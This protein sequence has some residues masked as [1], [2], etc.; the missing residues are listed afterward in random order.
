MPNKE[1]TQPVLVKVLYLF[2][3]KRR[4]SDVSTFLKRL[5]EAGKIRLQ[6]QEFDI[7]RSETHD[8][9]S[10][11]LWEQI[12][13]TLK[14]GGWFL[15]VSPPCNTFS[16][17]RFQWR[18]YPGP[19]PLRSR[20][21]PKGFPWL[22]NVNAKIVNEANEFVLQCI[23][24]CYVVVQHDG[25]FL[26]EHPEDLGIVDGEVP[27]SIWQ[28]EEI[29]NLLAWCHGITMAI[30]Q[31]QFGALTS[32]PTRLMC[33]FQVRD[34][35]CHLGFP[36]FDKNYRYLG[37]LPPKCGHRHTY[38]LMGKTGNRWNT[39]P[40]AAY[41]PG[42]CKFIAD[43]I[44]G[45]VATC[46][47]G[48]KNGMA[49]AHDKQ[50]ATLESSGAGAPLESSVVPSHKAA[51][52]SQSTTP[53]VAPLESSDTPSRTTMS[54][55]D[56]APLTT[57]TGPEEGQNHACTEI[58]NDVVHETQGFDMESCL[59]KGRPISVEWDGRRREFVDGFG[60]CSPTRWAPLARGVRRSDTMKKLASETFVLLRE[61]VARC[62]P[63]VRAAAFKLVTGKFESSPFSFEEL[64][65]LR[66]K[67][68]SLLADPTDALVV[69]EG[70]PFLLRGL[71]QW[72]TVFE[73]PDAPT[74]VDIEDSFAT[75][76]PLGVDAPLPRTPQVY[77]EKVKH[78]KLDDSEFN[79]IANNYQSAQV[80]STELET[81]FR[82]EEAM[83]R[84]YPTRLS[85]LKQE[86]GEE[87]IRVAAMAAIAKPDGTVRPL[88]DGTHSV[89][90]NNRIV[91]RDQIQC[92]GP[93]EVAAVVRESVETLEAPFCVSADIKAAHRLV[94]VRRCDW[95]YMCCKA[96]TDSPTVWVNKVGTFG[97]SSAPY[98]WAKLFAMVGRFVGHL[99]MNAWFLHL[100]YVDDLHG[101][102]VGKEKFSNL[103]V[104]ILAFELIG[105]PFAYHKFRG[106][107][108]SEFVGY[109]L[110]YDLNEV[111][112]SLRR[113]EW[114]V[115]WI[116]TAA[117]KRFVVVTREFS[118]FLGR[119]GFVSQLL[120]WLKPHLSPLY[121][122]ASATSGSTVA[123]LP[124]A[125]ILTMTYLLTE[126]RSETY[127]VSAKRP[128]TYTG[129]QFRTDAKCTDVSVV[130]G[131]WEMSTGRWF[132]LSLSES[133]VPYL[134]SPGKG[135]QWASTS[136]ELLA[137]L[138]ALVVFGWTGAAR[139]RKELELCLTA[140]TDN[141]ANEYLSQKRSTTKWP[142]MLV[143][144]QLSS[145]L[146]RSRTGVRLKWRPRE[147]NTVADDITN[148]VF[149]QLDMDKRL[150]V[151]YE[152][153]PTEIIHA[154]WQ[155]KAD[156]D[157]ARLL[158]K[159]SIPKES[160]KK[161]KRVDK[162]P[163]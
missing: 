6:L 22:S 83:G 112:I 25:W 10:K 5:E 63:D 103:W 145:V 28:W 17:A 144:M 67:W 151:D 124:D 30:H 15:I 86:F 141:R 140:G 52:S 156:F 117:E 142:L 162:T 115:K 77:P 43:A 120:V 36:K 121:A 154:L 13:D 61:T 122:W 110:R 47:G 153:I 7:E 136:A 160:E 137:T 76:V 94:K 68:A 1:P 50:S 58:D 148:S 147:E 20:T 78:R 111:G 11:E 139:S 65:T 123:K 35:R 89:Q 4:Q 2:A 41:P 80:S 55:S 32:K 81:K 129:E 54:C 102:F 9:R 71:S 116:N 96:N 91:Y 19:R 159:A 74:L 26:L 138:A 109:Q 131:G 155:V 44:F 97:I 88:H 100:V 135:S 31:C 14:E 106:G 60:L 34:R 75:G 57:G 21:W 16:R 69:D 12:C 70:Q 93:A 143:N 132:Q 108:S 128:A 157:E 126:F 101:S 163:W 33:N 105:T 152:D 8:L 85:T 40:S 29:H 23:N 119:L 146:A 99:M 46:G 149:T 38:K 114:L 134:F 133:D 51:S 39:S 27:G 87:R 84:M 64:T 62:I 49:A 66:K 90:V 95:P 37:P 130:L 56:P 127:M 48:A 125:V 92:P 18:R 73:D 82:E 161:R 79:P 45:A 150:Q 53:A 113:G 98:W 104:W 24:A 107:F 72:L 158:A 118:E 59:N 42:M 3:G